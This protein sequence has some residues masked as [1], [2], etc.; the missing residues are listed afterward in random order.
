MTS[1]LERQ[2]VFAAL[3]LVAALSAAAALTLG[4]AARRMPLAVALPT[5]TLLAVEA[6]RS[7][8][9]TADAAATG[10]AERALLAWLGLLMLL[11]WTLGVLVGPP[12]FLALYLRVRSKE[13]WQAVL[14][15]AGGLALIV[16]VVLDRILQLP[17]DGAWLVWP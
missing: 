9:A 8:H 1:R 17:I 3:V 15:L 6:W 5:L 10:A 11:T 13:R 7:R 4:P 12:L 16:F 14:P 2:L